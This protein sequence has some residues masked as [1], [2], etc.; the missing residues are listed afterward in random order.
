MERYASA[1]EEETKAAMQK[2]VEHTKKLNEARAELLTKLRSDYIGVLEEIKLK[3]TEIDGPMKEHA[4]AEKALASAQKKLDSKKKKLEA[5]KAKGDAAKISAKENDVTTAESEV[6]SAKAA[7]EKAKQ[8]LDDK[9]KEIKDFK[10][11]KL[12]TALKNLTQLYRDYH[13]KCLEILTDY[14]T[15][16]EEI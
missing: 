9:T 13:Q 1:E 4:D 6:E 2:V 10:R 16:V 12:K 3:L 7:L 15:S 5:A 8:T 11:E 14:E